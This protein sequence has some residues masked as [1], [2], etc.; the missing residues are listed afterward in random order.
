MP[1]SSDMAISVQQTINAQKDKI[2]RSVGNI[3]QEGIDN[4]EEEITRILVG[5]KSDHLK[6]RHT[7]G[8]LAVIIPVE[9]YCAVIGNNS[10]IYNPPIDINAYNPTASNVTASAQAVKEAEWKRKPTALKTFNGACARAKDLIIYGVG[11]DSVVTIKQLYI[12]Y[13]GV[14][15]KKMM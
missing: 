5:V 3:T 1:D 13:G 4:L 14:T 10:W 15:P 7:N 9:Y 8:H 2:T 11:E 6:E 12:G